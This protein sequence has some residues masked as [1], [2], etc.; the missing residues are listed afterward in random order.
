MEREQ[1]LAI[2]A[3]VDKLVKDAITG[4]V[5]A[6]SNRNPKPGNIY[7]RR[8]VLDTGEL[9][10]D[11][12]DVILTHLEHIGWRAEYKT[13]PRETFGEGKR[14]EGPDRHLDIER[15]P[16]DKLNYLEHVFELKHSQ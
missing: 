3:S 6:D 11:V 15:G 5:I 9:T 16:Q 14:V 8:G 4:R 13:E 10:P 1:M 7:Y 12:R 2:K